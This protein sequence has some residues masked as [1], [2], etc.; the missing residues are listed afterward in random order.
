MKKT[1][2]NDSLSQA[3]IQIAAALSPQSSQTCRAPT[4]KSSHGKIID[5]RSKCY[6]QLTDLNTLKHQGLLSED[7]YCEE[8]KAIMGALM[9]LKE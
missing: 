9:K 1:N 2:P 7:E 4:Y 3:G 6:K 5:S 8:R